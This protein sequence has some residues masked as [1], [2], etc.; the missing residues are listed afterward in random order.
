L[1]TAFCKT[2][3]N[4]KLF[5]ETGQQMLKMLACGMRGKESSK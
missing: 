2:L 5:I 1:A 4:A 3:Q